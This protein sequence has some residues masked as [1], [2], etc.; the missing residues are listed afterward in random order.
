MGWEVA[1]NIHYRQ[2]IRRGLDKALG[3]LGLELTRTDRNHKSYLNLRRTLSVA[4]A[5]GMSVGDYIDFAYNVPG[6]TQHTIRRMSELGIFREKIDNICEIGPG[7]GRYLE[8][9]INIC[10]PKR[11]EIYE[12]ANNWRYW[13]ARKYHVIAHEADGMTLAQTESQSIALVHAHKVFVGL[14]V[15][16]IFNYF[17]EMLRV[18]APEGYAVF[19][20]LTENCLNGNLLNLWLDANPYWVVALIPEKVVLDFFRQRGAELIGRFTVPMKPGI[21]DYFVFKRH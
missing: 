2:Y 3:V 11:Y 6:A 20:L 1:M 9:T 8:T 16:S 7:S 18:C 17:L 5:A 19:D 21:T 15:V 4:K 14:T 12:T 10:H 13:L